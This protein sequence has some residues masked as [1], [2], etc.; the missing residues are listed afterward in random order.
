MTIKTSIEK[1][2]GNKMTDFEKEQIEP[3][4][5]PWCKELPDIL[6]NAIVD[7]RSFGQYEIW[8][9][10]GECIL[11]GRRLGF[12]NYKTRE[13]AVKAWNTRAPMPLMDTLVEIAKGYKSLIKRNI[14]HLRNDTGEGYGSR[15]VWEKE[16]AEVDELLQKLK[17]RGEDE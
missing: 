15:G 8:H 2:Q 6:E 16:I 1:I 12:S 9:N 3:L 13:G 4:P 17:E 10:H 7:H 11:A 5:C 14:K